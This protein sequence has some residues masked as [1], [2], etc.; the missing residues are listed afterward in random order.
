MKSVLI[1]D[2]NIIL[3]FLRQDEPAQSKTCVDLFIRAEQGEFSLQIDAISFAEVVWV[4]TSNYKQPRAKIAELLS[5]L[6]QHPAIIAENRDRLH[7]TLSLY[8]STNVDFID[9]YL[10][11]HGHETGHTIVTYDHDF[12]K[13]P[14]LT[15]RTPE[16]V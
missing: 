12:K 16:K 4:L 11:A 3:R 15:W 5:S 9:C 1:L 6:L 10:A 8:G 13:F 7:H 2:A 14:G